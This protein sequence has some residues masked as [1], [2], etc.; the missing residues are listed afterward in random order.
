MQIRSILFLL[1]PKSLQNTRRTR[2]TS[3]ILFSKRSSTQWKQGEYLS[4]HTDR[5]PGHYYCSLTINLYLF[6]L[7]PEDKLASDLDFFRKLLPQS[8]SNFQTV[9]FII[10]NYCFFNKCYYCDFLVEM[11][12]TNQ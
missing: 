9:F 1:H 12:R 8:I 11:I 3:L 4:S 5:M 6:I 2:T 10:V 7:I